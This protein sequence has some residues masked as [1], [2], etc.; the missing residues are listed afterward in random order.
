LPPPVV[1]VRVSTNCARLLAGL[2][3]VPVFLAPAGSLAAETAFGQ[4]TSCPLLPTLHVAAADLPRPVLEAVEGDALGLALGL[5]LGVGGAADTGAAFRTVVAAT[6]ATASARMA[7]RRRGLVAAL[8]SA[9][10]FRIC[11]IVTPLAFASVPENPGPDNVVN[12]SLNTT[13]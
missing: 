10:A 6:Q 7:K 3:I 11:H 4:A 13:L 1:Q 8:S 9:V 12:R 2:V 5:G